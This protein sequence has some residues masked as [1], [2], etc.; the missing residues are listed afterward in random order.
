M[1]SQKEN[2]SDV[3]RVYARIRPLLEKELVESQTRNSIQSC[4]STNNNTVK[5][6]FIN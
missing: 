2:D 5:Y 6:Y 3:F 4:I 1:K